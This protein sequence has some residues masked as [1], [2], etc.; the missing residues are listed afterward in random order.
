M[1]VEDLHQPARPGVRCAILTISDTRTPETDASGR[2]IHA[3][4]TAAGHA[5]ADRRLVPDDPQAVAAIT[6]EWTT[7]G[8]IRIVVTTGGTGIARR[9]RTFDA[10]APAFDRTLP[11]FGELFRML[12]FR[13][14]G[15]GAMLSRATAGIVGATA[16]FVLPGSEAAVRLAMTELIVPQIGHLAR[17][18][19]K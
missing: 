3:L 6:R 15:P 4:L 13:D 10:I 19:E 8:D 16:V 9:D 11:G 2:T 17:E 1:S 14:I 12:S 5:I 18:L 7:K